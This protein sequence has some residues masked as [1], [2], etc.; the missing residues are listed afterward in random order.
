VQHRGKSVSLQR[1]WGVDNSPPAALN[2]AYT[3]IRIIKPD[4][5]QKNRRDGRINEG[6]STAYLVLSSLI[7]TSTILIYLLLIGSVPVEAADDF[8]EKYCVYKDYVQAGLS[9]LQKKDYVSAI[10]NYGK[11]IEISPFEINNYY[12]RGIAFYRSGNE[13]EAEADFDKV[14]VLDPKMSSAYVYRGLCSEK[15]GKYKEALSDYRK[16]LE[17]KPNDAGIHN[18]LAYLY[19]TAGNEEVRDKGKALDHARK[20][21]ELSHEKNAEILDTLAKAYFINGQVKEAIDTEN[22]ALQLNPYNDEFKC[23]LREYEKEVKKQ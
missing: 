13:K 14:I 22:K 2:H 9:S 10:T 20:A 17:L 16:A 21:A 12:S 4:Y 6:L 15:I 8:A 7:L 5:F 3:H 11:A 1:V 23:R 19:T 18:N